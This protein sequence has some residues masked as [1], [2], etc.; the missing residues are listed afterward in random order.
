VQTEA[1]VGIAVI[2]GAAL[3]ILLLGRVERWTAGDQQGT[4]IQARFDSVAG[5][6]LKSPVE[7]AGV[8]VGEVES[9]ELAQGQALVTIR[10]LPEAKVYQGSQAAIRATGLLGE[11]YL[12]LLP[13]D[14][15][16]PVLREGAMVPQVG[17]SADL[18]RLISHLNAIGED[19]RTVTA[20]LRG[21]LGT[22]EGQQQLIDIVA[23]TRDFTAA[24]KE[25]GPEIMDHLNAIL[26]KVDTGEGTVGRLVN[27]PGLYEQL[28]AALSDVKRV[29]AQVSAGEGT[30]GKLINDPGLYERLDNAA[31][32]VE[33]I[34][35]KMNAGEGTI[36]RLLTDDSTV[37]S[38]N[39][40]AA[41]FG[42]L[43]GRVRRLKTYITFRNEFQ[44]D[45]DDTK[46]YFALR[47][48]PRERRSYILEVADDPRGKVT[49]S[50]TTVTTGGTTTTTT[51]LTNRRRFVISA[52]FAQ[53]LGRDFEVRGG[54]MEST[55]GVG[56]SYEPIRHVSML[57]DAWDFNS[58]RPR[59]DSPHVKATARYRLGPYFF[60][61]GGMDNILNGDYQTPF[62]GAALTF[63]DEDLKY[64]LG[65]AAS[66]LN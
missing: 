39:D 27:D 46:T 60:V 1:K 34:T 32:G 14:P 66:A 50:T 43:G 47:L 55:G 4:R 53:R 18:D 26:A 45:T 54:L 19:L 6:E 64:L 9:I 57:L 20:S 30:L 24:L 3:L 17:G 31:A 44:F 41:T 36:G 42:E 23:N 12:E 22:D 48:T 7:V 35:R 15:S 63:E 28:D 65:S 37:E 33:E 51:A 38:I 59:H 2:L 21:A 40:A 13:G 58:V 8:K 11:K 62:V 56:A 49:E 52:M 16:G 25:R 61:Q 10:L 5:L 29:M